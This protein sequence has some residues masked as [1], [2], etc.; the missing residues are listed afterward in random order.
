V[1]SSGTY[2]STTN[3]DQALCIGKIGPINRYLSLFNP[4]PKSVG[5]VPPF[6]CECNLGKFD[7]AVGLFGFPLDGEETALD[8]FQNLRIEID[9]PAI[10]ANFDRRIGDKQ[11]ISFI[12]VKIIR[13]SLLVLRAPAINAFLIS[14]VLCSLSTDR[15]ISAASERKP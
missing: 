7:I 9:H 4:M 5:A 2:W 1:Y 8:F 10:Q 11:I 15:R 12:R 3:Y 14:H 13:P 6:L